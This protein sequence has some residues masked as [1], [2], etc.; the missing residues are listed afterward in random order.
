MARASVS[1]NGAPGGIVNTRQVDC[2]G[3]RAPSCRLPME[4]LLGLG[5]RVRRADVHP[6]AVELNGGE[7]TGAL[8]FIPQP[9]DREGPLGAV[10]EDARVIDGYPREDMRSSRL[11]AAAAW[12]AVRAD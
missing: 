7:A 9:Q 2:V 4:A 10:A 3:F 1:R 12:P 6:Q 11:V 5:K 8:R